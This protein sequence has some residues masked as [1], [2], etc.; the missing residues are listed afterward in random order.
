M[1][2]RG[3][4]PG[5]VGEFPNHVCFASLPTSTCSRQDRVGESGCGGIDE[6]HTL[7]DSLMLIANQTNS[8]VRTP[9]VGN[10]RVKDEKEPAVCRLIEIYSLRKS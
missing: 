3:S 7:I 5:Q 4:R 2:Y 6:I 1:S 10:L 9:E 8:V